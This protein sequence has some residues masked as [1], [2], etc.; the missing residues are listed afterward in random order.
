MVE[1]PPTGG[2][3]LNPEEGWLA[4]KV[5]MDDG[6]LEGA[7]AVKDGTLVFE[8]APLNKGADVCEG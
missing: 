5:N 8:A 1:E 4:P 3:R 2:A 6:W 7:V